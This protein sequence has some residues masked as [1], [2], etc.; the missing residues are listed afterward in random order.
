[1]NRELY[2]KQLQ[3]YLRRLPKEDYEQ[4]MEYFEEHFDDAGPENEQQVLEDLGSPREAAAE[5][6]ENLLN[7]KTEVSES[8]KK[9]SL[10]KNVLI[11]ILAMLAAPIGVPLLLAGILLLF[12]GVLLIVSLL[13]CA[14]AIVLSGVLVGGKLL[15]RG[16]VAIPYS[17]SGFCLISGFGIFSIGL[18]ILICLGLC[19]LC[20]LIERGI[21]SIVKKVLQKRRR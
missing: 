10:G 3:K 13:V 18:S 15:I 7:Q 8:G 6:L 1:M 11:A 20:G 12:A 5:L 4:A 2:L 9:S 19:K 21:V 16:I 14:F 17:V